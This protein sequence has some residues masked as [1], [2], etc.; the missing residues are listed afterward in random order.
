M[1]TP[2]TPKPVD[3]KEVK[4]L[5]NLPETASD[6]DIITALV[7]MV[8]VLQE[9]MDGLLADATAAQK[10]KGEADAALANRELADFADIIPEARR[11]FW[12]TQYL[13]NRADTLA[14]LT[15][16][17]EQLAA[18]K[19]AAK[20]ET[21]DTPLKNRRLADH[22]PT[23]EELA[24]EQEREDSKAKAKALRNRADVIA[25]DQKIPFGRAFAQA[26]R[27]LAASKTK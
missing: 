26:E 7:D 3:P 1:T 11:D 21:G 18:V 6:L 15:E 13:A 16:L 14:M 8:T 12:R 19:P 25:K 17:R 20:D 2:A 23:A 5:L 27:E 9:K 22:T 4:S 24:A 10:A